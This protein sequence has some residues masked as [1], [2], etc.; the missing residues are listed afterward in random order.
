MRKKVQLAPMAKEVQTIY[1]LIVLYLLDCV[2]FPLTNGQICEF[3]LEEQYTDYFT[4]QQTLTEML[5]MGLL[6]KEVIRNTS[7]YTMTESGKETLTLLQDEIS[8]GIKADTIKYLKANKFRLREENAVVADYCN[9]ENEGYTVKLQVKERQNP[10]IDLTLEVPIERQAI[11]FCD[12]W[13]KK[14]S[15]IYQYLMKELMEK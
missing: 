13:K 3:I 7:N 4:I 6:E 8:D 1:K 9:N 12:N 11:L 15:Q 10:I 2:E 14:S 5:E